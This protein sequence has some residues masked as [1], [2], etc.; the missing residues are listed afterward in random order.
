MARILVLLLLIAALPAAAQDR[1][2]L[3]RNVDCAGA[4]RAIAAAIAADPWL[5]LIDRARSMRVAE[6]SRLLGP[7][8]AAELARQDEAQRRTLSR[9]LFFTAEGVLE[10]ESLPA[11]RAPIE[12]WLMQLMRMQPD[13]PPVLD[14]RWV[15]MNGVAVV[16]RLGGQRLAVSVNTVDPY[17][18]AWT[19]EYEGEGRAERA[20]WMETA[21]GAVELS[22]DGPMLAVAMRRPADGGAVP[23]CGAAGSV[24]GRYFRVGDAD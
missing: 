2:P 18:L 11:L 23:F 6:L 22:W 19:C 9:E 10:A 14:G 16:H 13:P 15:G 8:G 3:R 1:C 20:D 24:A 4:Q 7:A 12:A 21:D 5:A 17:A